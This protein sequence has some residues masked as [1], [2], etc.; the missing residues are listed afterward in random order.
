MRAIFK[1]ALQEMSNA[2]MNRALVSTL[3]LLLSVGLT[4][5]GKSPSSEARREERPYAVRLVFFDF[6]DARVRL[7]IDGNLIVDRTMASPVEPSNGLN[8]IL[9]TTLTEENHF[10]LG[11]DKHEVRITIHADSGTRIVYITP[12]ND[13]NIWTSDSDVVQLD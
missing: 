2:R 10:V 8:V 4:A 1:H 11:W 5:C 13:P 6:H 9:E 12:R 7:S 3:F